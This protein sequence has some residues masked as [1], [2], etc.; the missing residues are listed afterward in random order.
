MTWLDDAPCRGQLDLMFDDTRL[1]EALAV[2]ANCPRWRRQACYRDAKA[3]EYGTRDFTHGVAGGIPAHQRERLRADFR[4]PIIP[5]VFVAGTNRTDPVVPLAAL[6]AP[7]PP[8]KRPDLAARS[9]S[10]LAVAS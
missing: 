2:C 3:H 10:R 5:G 9:A 4:V 6:N 1:L 7:K 8:V